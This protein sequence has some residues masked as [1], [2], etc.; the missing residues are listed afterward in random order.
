MADERPGNS[1]NDKLS[2]LE[3]YLAKQKQLKSDEPPKP[4]RV[5]P[6][7]SKTPE[8]PTD[9]ASAYGVPAA[10]AFPRP[11]GEPPKFGLGT[12]RVSHPIPDAAPGGMVAGTA[13]NDTSASPSTSSVP[14]AEYS[15]GSHA[16]ERTYSPTQ[17]FAIPGEP[18][19]FF[20]RLLAYF[21]DM[22]IVSAIAAPVREILGFVFNLVTFGNGALVA[23]P[24]AFI[25]FY[26]TVFAY[27]GYFYSEKGAS[28]GKML[29]KIQIHDAEAPFARLSYGKAFFR[30]SIGKIAAAAPLFIG[31][32][33]SLFRADRRALHDLLFDTK[34]TRTKI[35]SPP[36]T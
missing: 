30:E 16:S 11:Q 34:V 28:P 9:D 15:D 26:G 19:G 27:F 35:P 36:P 21:I 4:K 31:F 13:S 29:F 7:P 3:R 18:A 33:V 1:N 22:L 32:L 2:P 5:V 20:I 25:S 24:V 10:P 14:S 17:T 23:G 8:I 6:Q 12:R